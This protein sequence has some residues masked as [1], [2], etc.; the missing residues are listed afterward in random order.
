MASQGSTDLEPLRTFL[1]RKQWRQRITTYD[2]YGGHRMLVM[3]E[4]APSPDQLRALTAEF[5]D[6]YDFTTVRA[7]RQ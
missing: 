6:A 5:G 2:Q 3:L 7:R 4:P 1:R